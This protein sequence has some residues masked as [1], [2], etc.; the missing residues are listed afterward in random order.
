MLIKMDTKLLLEFSAEQFGL[1][2]RRTLVDV[3]HFELL[4]ESIVKERI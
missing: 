4:L 3:V 2:H 1:T